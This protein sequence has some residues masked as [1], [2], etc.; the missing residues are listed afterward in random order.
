MSG[1]G[2]AVRDIIIA[3]LRLFMLQ[4]ILLF[5]GL[6][7]ILFNRVE[8]ANVALSLIP[9]RRD[10]DKLSF[11]DDLKENNFD[12]IKNAPLPPA[13]CNNFVEDDELDDIDEDD[14]DDQSNDSDEDD[15]DTDK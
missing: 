1:F 15:E 5:T 7:H 14:L 4:I 8:V 10:R 11:V 12:L 6:N 13:E 2:S 9:Q 3:I